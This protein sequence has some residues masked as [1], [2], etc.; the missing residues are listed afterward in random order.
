MDVRRP[1]PASTAAL[2]AS[3]AFGLA[4]G[5]G[6]GLGL[7]QGVS[8]RPLGPRGE[9]HLREEVLP[10]FRQSDPSRRRSAIEEVARNKAAV[11][12]LLL[13]H[14]DDVRNPLERRSCMLAVLEIGGPIAARAAQHMFAEPGLKDGERCIAAMVLGVLGSGDQRKSLRDLAAGKRTSAARRGAILALGRLGDGS[15]LARAV[16]QLGR[17]GVGLDRATVLIS[18]GAARDRLLLPAALPYLQDDDAGVRRAA[19]FAIG[20]FG[21]PSSL[22]ALL[23][24]VESERS[25]EVLEALALAL[26]RFDDRE[27]REALLTLSASKEE[28][29]WSAGWVALAARPDTLDVLVHRV[30]NSKNAAR[31][32]RL[33]L[34]CAACPNDGIREVL[35]ELLESPRAEIRGAAGLALAARGERQS[36]AAILS[37]LEREKRDDERGDAL[38]AAGALV[39]EEALPVLDDGQPVTRTDP[40]T[41][42]VRLTLTGRLDARVLQDH[43]DERLRQM[44]ARLWDRREVVA[45]ELIEALFEL[46]QLDRR[47]NPPSGSGGSTP[48]GYPT[49][50]ARL[51]RDSS[52]ARDLERWFSRRPYLPRP[53]EAR[54]LR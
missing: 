31:T 26:A 4:F 25:D 33:A 13:S 1:N 38:L 30:R 21:D 9:A 5:A 50:A 42:S 44:R 29:V 36:G 19:A 43:V 15:G 12:P 11:V 45:Q 28:K 7:A 3:L 34:A 41:K 8:G 18:I 23:K 53:P 49:G 48:P 39:V 52:F 32:A 17:E 20:E 14:F 35:E 2:F 6:P 16:D 37:W 22:P 54:S 47:I 24:A 27:S 40:L 51:D 10:D 46:D